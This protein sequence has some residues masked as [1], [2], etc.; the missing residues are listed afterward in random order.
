MTAVRWL[1]LPLSILATLW[2]TFTVRQLPL[3]TYGGASTT[4][5]LLEWAAALGWLLIASLEPS[6]I[7]FLAT[8]TLGTTWMVPELAGWIGGPAFLRTVANAWSP[9]LLAA[10]VIAVRQIVIRSSRDDRLVVLALVGAAVASAS[11][12]FL[13]DPFYQLECWRTC[14]HNPLAL[15]GGNNLGRVLDSIGLALIVLAAGWCAWLLLG[16]LRPRKAR[17]VSLS[18]AGLLVLTTSVG[19][20]LLGLLVNEQSSASRISLAIWCNWP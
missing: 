5:L 8:I 4:L 6:R 3:T 14:E 10:I 17:S 18:A 7:G 2:V 1:A 15:R 13:V 19:L 16:D 11:R 9:V 20:N 12:M